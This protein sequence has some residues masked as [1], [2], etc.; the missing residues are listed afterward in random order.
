V[1]IS[2]TILERLHLPLESCF[3]IQNSLLPLLNRGILIPR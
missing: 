1:N 3:Y 2:L